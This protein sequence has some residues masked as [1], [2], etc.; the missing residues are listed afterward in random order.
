VLRNLIDNAVKYAPEGGVIRVA[1]RRQ[2]EKAILSVADQG[3]GIPAEEQER[4]F[5]RFYRV[6]SDLGRRT[7][8]AGLGLAI[9]RGL[10]ELHDGAIWCEAEPGVGSTFFVRLP[11]APGGEATVD[12]SEDQR[13]SENPEES[14]S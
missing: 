12:V 7:R 10:V 3:I 6:E 1:G 14:R 13:Q 2:D 5:E 8:G 9:S 11:A 4:I